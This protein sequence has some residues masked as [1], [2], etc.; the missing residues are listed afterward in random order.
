[1]TVFACG[2]KLE[3][4]IVEFQNLDLIAVG[5]VHPNFSALVTDRVVVMKPLHFNAYSLVWECY[6]SNGVLVLTHG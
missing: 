5:L 2:G 3:S 6:L 4:I 1:V